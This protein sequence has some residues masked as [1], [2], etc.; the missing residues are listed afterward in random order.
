M[1]VSRDAVMP[2]DAMMIRDAMTQHATPARDG[3]LS[4]DAR[5]TR[6]AAVLLVMPSTSSPSRLATVCGRNDRWLQRSGGRGRG[7]GNGRRRGGGTGG[8]SP[9]RPQQQKAATVRP[10]ITEETAC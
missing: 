1:A 6:H 9:A 2:R 4:L 7:R 8:G 10:A 5:L 3:T